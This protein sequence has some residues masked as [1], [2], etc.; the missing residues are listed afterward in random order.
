MNLPKSSESSLTF[1]RSGFLLGGIGIVRIPRDEAGLFA[2]GETLGEIVKG[3]SVTVFRHSSA[4][5]KFLM[6]SVK[7]GR[8][9][10][11]RS[12]CTGILIRENCRRS[13]W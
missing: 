3:T 13:C 11:P 8:V 12:I 5:R 6:S 4:T 1:V 10:T 7:L 9:D 2:V